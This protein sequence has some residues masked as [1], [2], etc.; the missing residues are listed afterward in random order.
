MEEKYLICEDSLEGIFTGIYDAYALR[1]GHEHVHIQVGEEENLRLFATYLHILPDSVKT[2][3]VA[4][5]LHTIR[6]AGRR[7]PAIP[8]K[9]RPFT[10]LWWMHSQREAEAG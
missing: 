7:H 5:T 4:N 9:G 8:T 6:S 1:E 3:K 2:D 10:G